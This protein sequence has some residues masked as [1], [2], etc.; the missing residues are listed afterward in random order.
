MPDHKTTPMAVITS[1]AMIRNF[2]KS[3]TDEIIGHR[4]PGCNRTVLNS[5]LRRRHAVENV[6]HRQLH[7]GDGK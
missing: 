5:K 7:R 2:P 4:P 1:P 6:Q 3:F